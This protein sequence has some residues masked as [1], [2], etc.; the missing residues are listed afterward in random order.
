MAKPTRPNADGKDDV[1]RS[2]A[3]ALTPYLRQTLA[4]SDA[5]E[6]EYYDQNNSPLGRRRHLALV[7]RGALSGRKVGKRVLVARAAMR[8]FLEEHPTAVAV[9]INNADPLN[10]W[11]LT[12]RAR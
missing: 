6:P 11:G 12:R 4:S 8:A 3:Q 5:K 10:D 1:L 2:L 7:R 9:A